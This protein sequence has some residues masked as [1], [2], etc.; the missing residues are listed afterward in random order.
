MHC[1]SMLTSNLFEYKTI[2][3]LIDWL[4]DWSIEVYWASM[5]VLIAA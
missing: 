4:I 2:D 1:S 5:E 3:W